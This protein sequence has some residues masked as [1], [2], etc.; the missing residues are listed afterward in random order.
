MK[1]VLFSG[2][3]SPLLG[4]DLVNMVFKRPENSNI[5]EWDYY[6][7]GKLQTV[8]EKWEL[9]M[10]NYSGSTPWV[11]PFTLPTLLYPDDQAAVAA[12]TQ[13]LNSGGAVLVK[14]DLIA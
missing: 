10:Y 14:V 1:K 6:V 9:L 3:K 13:T 12:V 8:K 11:C 4:G 7:N 5:W 2:T